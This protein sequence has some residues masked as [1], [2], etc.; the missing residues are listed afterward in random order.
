[1]TIQA[2]VVVPTYRRPEF[3][4]RC[5]AALVAQDFDTRS[6]EIIV[7][8]NAASRDTRMQVERWIKRAARPH[9]RYLAAGQKPGPAAARNAGWRAAQGAIIAFTDDDCVPDRGWLK[10]GMSAFHDGL[11][12]ASGRIVMPLP[13]SPTDYERNEAS[14]Q[15]VEFVTANCFCRREVLEKVGGFD[16]RF[17]TAWREDSDLHFTLLEKG[18]QV[19]HAADALV[20]HP[21]RPAPWGISLLQQRKSLFNALLYKKHPGFYRERIQTSPPWHYYATVAALLAGLGLGLANRPVPSVAAFGLWVLLT[22]R[23]CL[24]RLRDTSHSPRHVAEMI[25]TSALIPPISVF[26]RLRGAVRFRVRFL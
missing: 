22:G 7:A 18:F 16:E 5:L 11:A 13:P 14:L 20:V 12:A 17:A 21:V 26:W 1:V 6:Y 2:S 15:H 9:I 3:L 4:D 10:A 23:F 8:D 24:L 25:V 19:A